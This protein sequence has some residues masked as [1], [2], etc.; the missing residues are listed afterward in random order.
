[1]AQGERLYRNGVLVSGEPVKA[2]VLGDVTAS[3]AEFGCVA[4]HAKSGMGTV[5]GS[6]VAVPVAW[7]FLRAPRRLI[8][9]AR[10]AYTDETLAR[11]IREG[12]DPGGNRLDPLMPRYSL[13]EEDTAALVA[14]LKQLSTGPSPGAGEDEM[15]FA[16]VVAP[17]ARRQAKEAMLRVTRAFV[18]NKNAGTQDRRARHIK[19]WPEYYG[20]WV[21]H[22]WELHGPKEA[23]GGQLEAYYRQR[24]VFVVVSGIGGE[25][26]SPIHRFCEA[27]RLPCLLPNVENPPSAGPGEYSVYFS[28]GVRLEAATIAAHLARQDRVS[29]VLQVFR[30]DTMGAL[31]A[32]AL[33]AELR[34]VGRAQIRDLAPL[35]PRGLSLATLTQKASAQGPSAVVLWTNVS[36]LQSMAKEGGSPPQA[37]VYLSATSLGEFAPEQIPFKS[38]WVVS[39]YGPPAEVRARFRRVQ[40]WLSDQGIE[41]TAT[42]ARVMDQTFFALTILNEAIMHVKKNFLRDYLLEV[43]DHF[44]GLEA[45]SSF[46]PRL[47]FGPGQRT[48]TKGCYLIPLMEGEARAEW[49]VP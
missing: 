29:R 26:W 8:S 14:Y 6:R 23:W 47:S 44:S 22:E 15:H 20:Q 31:G 4:C 27:T 1:V 33:S 28:A 5:E 13:S 45:L 40:S 2:T 39:P 34:R 36:D 16:I 11:A 37:P 49:L 41:P 32:R 43:M 18:R 25:D 12:I 38:G 42:E 10:P 19:S 30:P 3:G 48:L 17:G 9:R 21:M 24:P 46:Y 7:P 35:D